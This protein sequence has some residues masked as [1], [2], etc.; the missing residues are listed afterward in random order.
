MMLCQLPELSVFD[1]HVA[2]LVMHSVQLFNV[3]CC[4]ALKLRQEHFD[5]FFVVCKFINRPQFAGV[6]FL[7][8]HIG[9]LQLLS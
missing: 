8:F 9:I 2:I 6:I 5:P 3:F 4:F 7:Q 1:L